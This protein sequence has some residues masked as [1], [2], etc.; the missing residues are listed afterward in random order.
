MR[1]LRFGRTDHYVSAVSLGT[2]GQGGPRLSRG[3]SVGWSGNDDAQ[4]TAA[5]QRAYGSG[6]NHWDTADVYG[7]GHAEELIGDMWDRVPRESIFLATKV[8]WD[9]GGFDHYYH[10]DLVRR[11]LDR[12]L[13]LLRTDIIDLYYL[14]HCDFGPDDRY[15]DGALELLRYFRAEGRIRFIGLSD[16]DSTNIMRVIDRVQPDVVQPYRNVIDDDY[17]SSGLQRWVEEHDAGVAFFSPLKHGLL[18]GKNREPRRFPEGDY[19][20]NVPE[21][22]DAVALERLR[23][24]AEE[25]SK[26]FRRHPNPV[27]YGILGAILSD[28]RNSCVLVGQ[29]TPAQVEAAATAGDLL[30][31]EE[32]AWVRDLYGELVSNRQAR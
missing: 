4:A 22:G 29:R 20:R 1:L 26:R 15:L 14:H 23:R 13:E 12:S 2:W 25:L 16:W 3:E 5:L 30:S 27:L 9:K 11:N 24:N 6:I 31:P 8:G 7:D 18:M 19:R 32:A 10:P 17:A 21:F 28:S